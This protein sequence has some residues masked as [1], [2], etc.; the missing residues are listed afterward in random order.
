MPDEICA[1][2]N[3]EELSW[4]GEL[5]ADLDGCE[6]DYAD[7]YEGTPDQAARVFALPKEFSSLRKLRVLKLDCHPGMTELPPQVCAIYQLGA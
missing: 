5:P 4:R 1:L 2:T 7:D 6:D 3:L